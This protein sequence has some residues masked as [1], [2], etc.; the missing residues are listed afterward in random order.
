[1]HAHANTHTCT[2][3]HIEMVINPVSINPSVDPYLAAENFLSTN[4]LPAYYLDQVAEFIVQNAGE[5]QGNVGSAQG[6]DPF[7]G[8]SSAELE[9]RITVILSS[10]ARCDRS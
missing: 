9:M 8:E 1:M 3:P 4:N 2:Q 7:T 5:Y 10:I 6:A